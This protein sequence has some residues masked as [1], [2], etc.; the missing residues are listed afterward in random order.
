MKGKH[1]FNIRECNIVYVEYR[2]IQKKYYT[3]NE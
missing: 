1:Y 3:Y 2:D